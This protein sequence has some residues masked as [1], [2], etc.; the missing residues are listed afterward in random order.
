[1]ALKW[2]DPKRTKFP[3]H[4]I[5]QINTIVKMVDTT[6]V[7]QILE[8]DPVLPSY[9][10]EPRITDLDNLPKLTKDDDLNAPNNNQYPRLTTDQLPE[11]LFTDREQFTP[12]ILSD[13]DFNTHEGHDEDTTEI[14]DSPPAPQASQNQ[15][16][17]IPLNPNFEPEELDESIDYISETDEFVKPKDLHPLETSPAMK[18]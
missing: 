16:Q 1:M 12:S 2:T 18:T 4:V 17:L 8:M 6:T 7:R 3:K 11:P 5:Q 10:D 15:Q 9:P 14:P 13:K